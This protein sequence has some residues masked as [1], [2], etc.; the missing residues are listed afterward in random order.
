MIK[1]N[2]T[3][4]HLSKLLSEKKGFSKNL[5]NKLIDD[6]LE[7]IILNI[8]NDNFNLKN[9]GSFKILNKKARIGRNPKT[10][11]IYEISERKA[12]SFIPSKKLIKKINN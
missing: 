6:L 3:K 1:S 11:E 7:G 4:N 5:S 8:K 12:L 9:F 2:F 10:N